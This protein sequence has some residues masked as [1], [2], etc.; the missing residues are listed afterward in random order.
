MSPGLCH[1]SCGLEIIL[2]VPSLLYRESWFQGEL[3]MKVFEGLGNVRIFL[4][5]LRN[6]LI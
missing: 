5:Q 3:S 6:F 1:T 4:F 2:Q